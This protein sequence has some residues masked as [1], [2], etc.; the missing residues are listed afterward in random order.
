MAE[1]H[2][3]KRMHVLRLTTSELSLLATEFRVSLECGA[4]DPDFTSV[5]KKAE[6]AQDRAAIATTKQEPRS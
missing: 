4:E 5:L 3:P 1:Q 6:A 2:T